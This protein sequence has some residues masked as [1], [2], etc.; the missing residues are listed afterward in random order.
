M[1]LASSDQQICKLCLKP[2]ELRDSHIFTGYIYRPLYDPIHR[3]TRVVEREGELVPDNPP[4]QQ[5]AREKLLCGGCEH[6]LNRS[7]EQPSQ[8]LWRAIVTQSP[9]GRIEVRQERIGD[10]VMALRFRG[11]NADRFKLFLLAQ[12]WRASVATIQEFAAVD[13]GAHECAVR[14]MLLHEN[15]GTATDFP[16]RFALLTE[17]GFG[18]MTTPGKTRIDGYTGYKVLLPGV[19]LEFI[20]ARETRPC[21]TGLQPDGSL[22]APLVLRHNAPFVREVGRQ[23]VAAVKKPAAVTGKIA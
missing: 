10:E 16:C 8:R 4:P 12:L 18:L 7:Y 6:F 20:A 21:A 5:G 23:L 3:M 2:R 13:L 11:F 22:L 1:N 15:P 17:P 14:G 9:V 19:I